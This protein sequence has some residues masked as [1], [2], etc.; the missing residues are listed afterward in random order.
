MR[1]LFQMNLRLACKD[2]LD[3]PKEAAELRR[4]LIQAENVGVTNTEV[5]IAPATSAPPAP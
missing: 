2:L 4:R 1:I 5:P 3:L